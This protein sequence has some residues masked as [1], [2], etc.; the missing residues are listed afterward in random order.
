MR[1]EK[2]LYEHQNIYITLINLISSINERKK[3]KKNKSEREKASM[4]KCIDWF[5][6]N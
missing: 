1:N 5:L 2:M 3:E 4:N 6:V